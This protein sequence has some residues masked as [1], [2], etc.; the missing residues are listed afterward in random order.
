MMLWHTRE[1]ASSTRICNEVLHLRH[2]RGVSRGGHVR[3]ANQ[4]VNTAQR[5]DAAA[6][7]ALVLA[8]CVS[9]LRRAHHALALRTRPFPG[10]MTS[11]QESC[12]LSVVVGS[13]D[14]SGALR[15]CLTALRTTC[16]GIDAEILVVDA[17]HDDVAER[18]CAEFPSVR[19]T[20]LPIGTLV[21][22]SL[23]SGPQVRARSSGG[24]HHR[25][26]RRGA[27]LGEG[28]ARG[29]RRRCGR[30]RRTARPA[31][32]EQRDRARNVLPALLGLVDR[33]AWPGARDRGRQR[34]V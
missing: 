14:S 30:C 22:G 9:T 11:A 27:G 19:L 31:R 29:N 4:Q 25:P 8:R 15:D 3:R 23:G 20:R 16:D 24:I 26:M 17:S 28:D 21:P 33:R 13:A 18:V 5:F 12:E 34:R 2:S 32:G 10:P 1:E 7:G 6:R